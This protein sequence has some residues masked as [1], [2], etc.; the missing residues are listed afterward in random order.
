[1][2]SD[3]SSGNRLSLVR[4]VL[5]AAAGSW[6]PPVRQAVAASSVSVRLTVSWATAE[7]S[8]AMGSSAAG[9]CG[10]ICARAP[11]IQETGST[12]ASCVAGSA[13]DSVPVRRLH[14]RRAPAAGSVEA[15]CV[16]SL[17]G[18]LG[19]LAQRVPAG[20]CSAEASSLDGGLSIARVKACG[21]I[22]EILSRTI[23]RI[24]IL[25]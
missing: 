23:A 22:I 9:S 12:E 15:S 20:S 21:S 6:R 5:L 16:V 8:H 11:H 7:A 17:S 19:A 10:E 18:G 4:G 2:V 13:G 24:S 25:Q 1:V 3:R 14:A